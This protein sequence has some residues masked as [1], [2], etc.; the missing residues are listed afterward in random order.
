MKET[1]D[2]LVLPF[3]VLGKYILALM[4]VAVATAIFFFIGRDVLGEAV[5][6]LLYL[7]PISWVTASWGQGPG[8]I[9]AVV[10]A[11]AFNFF[12]IP[13]YYTLYIG[14]LEGWLLLGIFLVVA[15]V[16][17][18]RIQV[19]F[20]KAQR[21]E[22]EAIFMYELSTALAGARKIEDVAR[23]LAGQIQQ[24]Y[25]AGLV[26]VSL[27][28]KEGSVTASLPQGARMKSK[29]D[30]VLPI[31]ASGGLVGEICLWQDLIPI[32]QDDDRLLRNFTAQAAL[33]LERAQ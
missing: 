13:P 1:T 33:A 14:R 30:R 25:Q 24:L 8:I 19:G 28:G 26:Q 6:A 29:P 2:H 31:L 17:V 15:I 22:R 12:F 20:A 9:A 5:I 18:G 32:P 4:T 10:S 11:L 16:V 23:I 21:H 3:E 27:E 7:I